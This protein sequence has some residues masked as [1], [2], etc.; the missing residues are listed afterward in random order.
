[1]IEKFNHKCNP[2]HTL[3]GYEPVPVARK[4][5]KKDSTV[6]LHVT[7]EEREAL[8]ELQEKLTYLLGYK[9]SKSNAIKYACNRVWGE[10][11]SLDENDV[12]HL[13]A[14]SQAVRKQL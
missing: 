11:F 13:A 6:T 10:C 2:C 8:D 1:M 3:D 14:A 9:I 5:K 4:R 12:D 7:G